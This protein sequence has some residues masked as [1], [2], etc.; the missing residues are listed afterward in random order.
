[1]KKQTPDEKRDL[2]TAHLFN[3]FFDS[4]DR[5]ELE[6]IEFPENNT[7][8]VMEELTIQVYALYALWVHYF[9]LKPSDSKNW[10]EMI[11]Y[12]LDADE[13]AEASWGDGKGGWA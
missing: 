3:A 10:R 7:V 4:K 1:M 11:R 2:Y 13:Q 5:L 12:V 8:S 9:D 6:K